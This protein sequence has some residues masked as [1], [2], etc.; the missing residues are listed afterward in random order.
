MCARAWPVSGDLRSNNPGRSL[1]CRLVDTPQFWAFAMQ[2]G[3]TGPVWWNVV[4]A[5]AF[6]PLFREWETALIH[7]RPRY[8]YRPVGIRGRSWHASAGVLEWTP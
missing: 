5:R 4:F 2:P 6:F 1:P 3:S 7:G 8:A